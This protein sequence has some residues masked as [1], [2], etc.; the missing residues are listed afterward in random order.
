MSAAKARQFAPEQQAG[1][2]GP[3]DNNTLFTCDEEWLTE[4]KWISR[5]EEPMK[6]AIIL[7]LALAGSGAS[8]ASITVFTEDPG[9]YG[10]TRMDLSGFDLCS[11]NSAQLRTNVGEFH[12]NGQNGGGRSVCG[13]NSAVQVQNHTTPAFDYGRSSSVPRGRWIDSNDVASVHFDV[14]KGLR[15]V[16]VRLSDIN[17]RPTP[18]GF[19]TAILGSVE[20]RGFEVQEDGAV[21]WVRY[22]FDTDNGN[23]IVFSNL[24]NDEGRYD[25]FG[26]SSVRG[27]ES[28]TPDPDA[29]PIASAAPAPVPL[30]GGIWLI[31]TGALALFGIRRRS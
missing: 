12:A 23:Q 22:R 4:R 3:Q 2:A 9:K 24:G 6:F 19:A 7:A 27:F 28:N 5:L 15:E 20:S 25:G 17:D 10:G 29:A 11:N 21:F 14:A 1:P 8:A 31:A 18:L 26:I 30:P 16:W 13:S